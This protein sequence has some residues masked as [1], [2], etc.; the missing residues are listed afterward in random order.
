MWVHLVVLHAMQYCACSS[1]NLAG[2]VDG[3]IAAAVQVP[4]VPSEIAGTW[5][6]G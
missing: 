1:P 4:R 2:A 6:V 5:V 3:G